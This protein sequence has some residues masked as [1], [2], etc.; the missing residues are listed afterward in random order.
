MTS[1]PRAEDLTPEAA[2][3]DFPTS[4]NHTRRVNPPSVCGACLAAALRRQREAGRRQGLEEAARS[5]LELRDLLHGLQARSGYAALGQ[6]AD[7]IRARA[8]TNSPA[9]EP[10]KD[11]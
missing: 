10:G 6:A 11:T 8:Q 9:A 1:D 2:A 4:C 7:C 5:L 3:R